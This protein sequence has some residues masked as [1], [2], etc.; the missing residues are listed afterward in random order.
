MQE[1]FFP[2]SVFDK[3]AFNMTS[4]FEVEEEMGEEDRV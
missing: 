3:L 1:G 2:V 4:C